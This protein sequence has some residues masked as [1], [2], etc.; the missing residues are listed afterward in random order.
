MYAGLRCF[1]TNHARGRDGKPLGRGVCQLDPPPYFPRYFTSMDIRQAFASVDVN[2]LAKILHGIWGNTSNLDEITQFLSLFC[3][4][5]GTGL[6]QG[7]PAST[8]LFN[9]YMEHLVDKRMR[10][11][12]EAHGICYT[13]YVDDMLFS[14]NE[15]IGKALRWQL[16]QVVEEAGLQIQHSK[17]QVL[18]LKKG[19]CIINGIGVR[20]P[21][22][23]FMPRAK[24]RKL[25][26]MLYL[27]AKK[28]NIRQRD[29][30]GHYG[31]FAAATSGCMGTLSVGEEKIRKL[32]CTYIRGDWFGD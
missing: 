19:P 31:F 13:R 15:P 12:C 6:I 5:Q 27:F 18:D 14:R 30:A 22:N 17:T 32:Y 11:F 3:F 29:V 8:D 7:A 1:V 9:L 26:G 21:C 23:T 2:S 20:L 25:R 28:R 16:A 4:R 10:A 24:L